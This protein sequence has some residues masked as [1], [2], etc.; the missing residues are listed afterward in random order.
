MSDSKDHSSISVGLSIL[1]I[2][3][4]IGFMVEG[5]FL[6]SVTQEFTTLRQETAST[7]ATLTSLSSSTES[8][9][10]TNNQ[11]FVTFSD[12]LY[13]EQKKTEDLNDTV[14]NFDRQV[15]KLSGS[16]TTLEKLTTTDPELLQKYS[17]IYFLNENYKPADLTVID[18]KYDYANGKEV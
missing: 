15:S 18:E 14:R 11:R 8:Y 16:V 4:V 10:D 3:F 7:T 17:K 5:Y 12:M 13:E 6:Y 1:L 2:L 9:F